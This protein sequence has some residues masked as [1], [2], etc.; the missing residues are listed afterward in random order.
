MVPPLLITR[1]RASVHEVIGSMHSIEVQLDN[2]LLRHGCSR[3]VLAG[4]TSLN[5][6]KLSVGC[7]K[8]RESHVVLLLESAM[9]T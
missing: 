7:D 8:A 6:V 4:L 9:M 1:T 3:I 2:I 5:S